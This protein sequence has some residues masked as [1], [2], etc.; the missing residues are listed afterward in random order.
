MR[1]A[2][3]QC[4]NVFPAVADASCA[5]LEKTR[6]ERGNERGPIGA[7]SQ[8]AVLLLYGRI[9]RRFSQAEQ[10]VVDAPQVQS[11]TATQVRTKEAGCTAG[12]KYLYLL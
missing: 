5:P 1:Q 7:K 8:Q 9:A 10:C 4:P 2:A 12:I 3:G 6:L 11:S